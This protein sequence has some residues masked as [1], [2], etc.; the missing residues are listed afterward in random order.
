[1]DGETARDFD[2]AVLVRERADGGYELQ[3]HIADVSEYVRPG[4]ALD[5]EAHIRGTS[6]Y[7][8]DRAI[9]ML[10]HELSTGICSLRPIEDRLVLS[11]LMQFDAAGNIESFEV[12]E[13]VIRSARAH[14][15]YRGARDHRGRRGDPR[16]L[17]PAR[18]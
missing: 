16:P 10:P 14:D 7:F 6:V 11:C 8:P 17:H 5:L 2:D 4:S 9:P 3:V 13:G 1:M 15:V 12:V 18:A